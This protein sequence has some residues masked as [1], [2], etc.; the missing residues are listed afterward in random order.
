M[1]IIVALLF[2]AATASEPTS[3]VE[4]KS[5]KHSKDDRSIKNIKAKNKNA[6]LCSDTVEFVKEI[7][8]AYKST[9]L[10]GAMCYLM[11]ATTS[12]LPIFM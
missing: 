4:T 11:A 1:R 7:I 12:I 6:S 2:A 9:T 5:G 10:E 8:T 3:I